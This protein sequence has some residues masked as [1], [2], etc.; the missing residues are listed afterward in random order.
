MS[1]A[2]YN[3]G[4]IV[5]TQG[6]KGEL[7]CCCRQIFLKRVFKKAKAHLWWI[8]KKDGNDRRG[9]ISDACKKM[10]ISSNLTDSMTLM[11]VEK[12][13]GWMLKVRASDQ[14]LELEDDSIITMKLLAVSVVT[15]DG[16]TLGTVTDI[17]TPGAND[18]WVVTRPVGKHVLL[19]V[20]DDVVLN[21]DIAAKKI[22]V[23]IMEGLID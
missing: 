10:F 5:N 12:Y 19:P 1:E 18:V 13:K 23:Y 3:V 11:Y 22:L 9:R 16:E 21:V 4:K 17:L 20:I 7:R 15:E 14:L 8:R 6:I 2:M